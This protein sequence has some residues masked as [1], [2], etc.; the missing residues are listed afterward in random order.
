MSQFHWDPETYLET[1]RATCRVST[2]SSSR[3]RG[4]PGRPRARA[5]ARD[6]HRR[7][8]PAADRV[9]S[10]RLGDRARRQPRHGLPPPRGV[11]RRELARIEDPLP[12]GPWY[13]VIGVPSLHHL[14]TDQ[15]RN[16]FRRVPRALTRGGRRRRGPGGDAGDPDRP[17]PTT[18][19][20]PESR[21]GP[22]RVGPVGEI[23]WQ[24]RDDLAVVRAVLSDPVVF[25]CRSHP[26][27]RYHPAS[28]WPY[29]RREPP[30]PAAT[31]A[32]RST[33]QARPRLNSCPRCHSPRL[34]HRVCPT[35]G[36][37]AGREVISHQVTDP[38]V[39]S[40]SDSE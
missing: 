19:S 36:T 35:C 32:E 40:A 28:Q 22:G 12:D 3:R 15:K 9:L 7:D 16:L 29:R 2:P 1:I 23:V 13:L 4:D 39:T 27:T 10:R 11:R 31:S 8:H 37:Y 17:L 26:E 5:R 18:F 21:R 30:A 24:V 20:P 38:T 34:P 25:A 33:R 14:T 6:G